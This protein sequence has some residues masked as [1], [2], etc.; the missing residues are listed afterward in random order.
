M[1]E[2]TPTK[3]VSLLGVALSSLA[4]LFMVSATD[5]SFSGTAL[6]VPDPFAPEK[7]VAVIDNATASYSNFLIANLIAP[8]SQ[9]FAIAADSVGWVAE[10][11]QD[12]ALAFMGIT[13]SSDT[14]AVAFQPRPVERVAGAHTTQPAVREQSRAGL[15]DAIY[16][17]LIE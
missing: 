7:V 8:A 17:L 11:A 10:N 12:G 15:L 6:S 5:A 14:E 1:T 3:V 2:E 9:D 4:F 13:P 16:S